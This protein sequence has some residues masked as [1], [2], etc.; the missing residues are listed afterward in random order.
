MATQMISRMIA[1]SHS[2]LFHPFCPRQSS[3]EKVSNVVLYVFGAA[4][5]CW[6]LYQMSRPSSPPPPLGSAPLTASP[7]RRSTFDLAGKCSKPSRSTSG[8]LST[9]KES[10]ANPTSD[11]IAD[12]FCNIIKA[13]R[14]QP[15]KPIAYDWTQKDSPVSDST[16]RLTVTFMQLPTDEG[17]EKQEVALVAN[18]ALIGQYIRWTSKVESYIRSGHYPEG[19]EL[20]TLLEVLNTRPLVFKD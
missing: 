19:M 15:G 7:R 17:T 6:A 18:S 3:T 20:K 10:K 14:K 2:H 8:A 13:A 9:E 12:H 4:V 5:A 11:E 16:P 1:C